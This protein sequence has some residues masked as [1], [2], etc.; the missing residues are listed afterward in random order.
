MRA[1]IIP[2]DLELPT[3]VADLT[4]GLGELQEIVGG[5][6]RPL[7]LAGSGASMY[8]DEEANLKRG[9]PENPRAAAIVDFM[10]ARVTILG[11]VV[12]LGAPDAE[13]NDTDLSETAVGMLQ[14]TIKFVGLG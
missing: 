5:Y 11:D 2:A 1:L 14:A 4:G 9:I 6:V 3:R 10:G 7:T 12:I 8:L 13:G